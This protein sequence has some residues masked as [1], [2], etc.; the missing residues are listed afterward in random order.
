MTGYFDIHAHVLPGIDDGPSEVDDA[1]AMLRAAAGCGIATIVATPHVRSDFLAVDVHQLADRCAE[2]RGRM[3][4]EAIGLELACGAEV[5]LVWAIE[6]SDEELRLASYGQRGTDLLIE[7]PSTSTAGLQTLL[8]ELQV[9][10]FRITL[11]H[12]ERSHDFQRDPAPLAELVRRGLLLQV[13]ADTLLGDERRS[14]T[15]RLGVELCLD[16]LVHALASDSHRAESWRPVTRLPEAVAAAANLLGPDRAR[17]MSAD[18]PAAI[19]N[20]A[21]LPEA[22]PVLAGRRRRPRRRRR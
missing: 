14:A 22:P 9:R 21:E 15:S 2:M 7:T 12:P 20:G 6:A 1:L 8:Y 16:G 4:A 5:S 11:A 3:A 19:F 18:A 10:G 13:N 17:W